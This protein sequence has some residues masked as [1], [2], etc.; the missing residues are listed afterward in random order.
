M[1][2]GEIPS[3]PRVSHHLILAYSLQNN[4]RKVA[5]S[6]QSTHTC[7]KLHS[8]HTNM[9]DRQR[10]VK[11]TQVVIPREH[12]RREKLREQKLQKEKR[13]KEEREK[14]EIK[15]A[16][17][18]H[19]SDGLGEV[20]SIHFGD[21]RKGEDFLIPNSLKWD[22]NDTMIHSSDDSKDGQSRTCANARDRAGLWTDPHFVLKHVVNPND[23]FLN[24]IARLCIESWIWECKNAS[25]IENR[26]RVS[27]VAPSCEWDCFRE[28][29]IT[30]MSCQ[31][32]MEHRQ[33]LTRAHTHIATA[34]N[35]FHW[36]LMG[37][38]QRNE[39]ESIEHVLYGTN[40]QRQD[41]ELMGVCEIIYWMLTI[42]AHIGVGNVI[43]GSWGPAFLPKHVSES[44]LDEAWKTVRKMR[45]CKKR[46]WGLMNFAERGEADLPGLMEKVQV[47]LDLRHKPHPEAGSHRHCDEKWCRLDVLRKPGSVDP[48][49]V[50]QAHKYELHNPASGD[51]LK[52]PQVP[53]P[54]PCGENEFKY[55]TLKSEY[56]KSRGWSVWSVDRKR[57]I[58]PK[59]PYIAI[60][61]T[62]AD[63][64]GEGE[65][66][67]RGRVNSC[68]SKYFISLAED[69][70]CVGIWWDTISL[71]KEPGIKP[72]AFSK[73]QS[74]YADAACTLVHD[75]YLLDFKWR[76]DGSPC[77][78]LVL[79]PWFSRAWTAVE[80]YYSD[81]VKVLYKGSYIRDLDEHI[82]AE[83]PVYATRAHWIASSMIRRL[84]K[85]SRKVRSVD[86]VIA[87]LKPRALSKEEDRMR[88]AGLLALKE[89]LLEDLLKVNDF[90]VRDL[91]ITC[92]ILKNLGKI[93]Y[94][95][96]LHHRAPMH[97]TGAFSWAPERL[98]DI[99]YA[100]VGDLE[101]GEVW[102]NFLT[103]NQNG[104]IEGGWWYRALTQK[105]CDS[106][107]KPCERD[108]KADMIDV[109]LRSWRNCILL[110][111]NWNEKGEAVLV[112][113]VGK[114]PVPGSRNEVV[115]CHYLG[116]VDEKDDS[117]PAGGNMDPRFRFGHIR[118]GNERGKPAIDARKLLQLPPASQM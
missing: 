38:K 69:Q 60:S 11:P 110:R 15:N 5:T 75:K 10:S 83:S 49:E 72:N 81:C 46:I 109:G 59:D 9:S 82:L 96:L 40:S 3:S 20:I 114:E 1:W 111:E 98:M 102:D 99:P 36:I 43:E 37:Y 104:T 118:L 34:A 68:L 12:W 30:T 90:E 89:E 8:S 61:H 87:I 35:S 23:A 97:E 116:P 50:P 14:E 2:G 74:N 66:K 22:K 78:A 25:C 27:R 115:D 63:G 39:A 106:G 52:V 41:V 21:E 19:S 85:K 44:A 79:S 45:I 42:Q 112:A 108:P 113:T 29:A 57:I 70:K 31:A 77:V 88:C 91:K 26:E 92:E 55:D 67:K 71:N 33:R 32:S 47:H 4:S 73:M 117:R 28:W 62:W 80:L 7:Q 6:S 84:R 53:N 51:R 48:M 64:T 86:D 107:L 94:R 54:P 58:D 16:M 105:D 13:E 76:K 56:E 95:S 93:G 100:S 103:I 17:V 24:R 101:G 65:G 18:A